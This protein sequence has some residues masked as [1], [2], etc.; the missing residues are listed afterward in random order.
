MFSISS[1]DSFDFLLF[2]NLIL[3][4]SK[5]RE[6]EG[7]ALDQEK[8]C[9]EILTRRRMLGLRLRKRVPASSL[10]DPHFT[11]PGVQRRAPIHQEEI[12]LALVL[13]RKSELGR[14]RVDRVNR[15]VSQRLF[16]N[17][18]RS[19]AS[20]LSYDVKLINTLRRRHSS[21]DSSTS[22]AA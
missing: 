13:H 12:E 17:W 9:L 4:A 10:R 7:S 18:Q 5:M 2:L 16:P 3:L 11:I 8:P 14:P 1:T 15:Q 22:I 19:T 21:A 20:Q 6:P